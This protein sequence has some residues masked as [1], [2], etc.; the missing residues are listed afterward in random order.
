MFWIKN[1]KGLSRKWHIVF[2]LA[3]FTIFYFVIQGYV[4]ISLRYLILFIPPLIIGTLLPD[5]L[6]APLNP[7]HRKAYHS[8]RA[9]RIMVY[10]VVPVTLTISYFIN[11]R[12]IIITALATGYAL[13]LCADYF[14]KSS[15]PE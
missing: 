14:S 8:K 5:A 3:A 7:W 11:F 12:Y 15:L 10:Y 9:L 13:H 1:K 4:N 6:E 2:S